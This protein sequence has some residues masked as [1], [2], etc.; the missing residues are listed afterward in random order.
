MFGNT[1]L[2]GLLGGLLNLDTKPVLNMLVSQPLIAGPLVGWI[3][4]DWTFGLITGSFLEL[5]WINNMPIG[6]SIPPNICLTAVMATAIG[7]FLHQA[8]PEFSSQSIMIFSIAV[9]VPVG[10]VSRWIEVYMRELNS[11]VVRRALAFAH[12]DN[13][14]GLEGINV[15]E[16]IVSFL[17]GFLLCWVCA[18]IGFDILPRVMKSMPKEVIEGLNLSFKYLPALG[19][20]VVLEMFYMK[21][22][23]FALVAFFVLVWVLR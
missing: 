6:I 17:E 7:I 20:A 2:V 8:L 10:L 5:I 16:I 11:R 18:L 12:H 1:L 4:G 14:I 19:L 21:K 13:L 22:S 23:F 9:T 15:L 3:L